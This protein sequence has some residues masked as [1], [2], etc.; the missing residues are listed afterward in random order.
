M[1][2]LEFQNYLQVLYMGNNDT[3][4]VGTDSWDY[5]SGLLRTAIN[6]WQ[7]EEGVEW[8]ELWV[9][10]SDGDGDTTTDGTSSTY[11]AA[12]DFKKPGGYL[13][14]IDSSG[15]KTWYKFIKPSDVQV[16]LIQN[17]SEKYF[18]IT[19]NERVGFTVNLSD[20]PVAGLTIEY[21]YYKE[22][23]VPISSSH[24]IEMNDAWFAVHMSL[25][26]L[27]GNAENNDKASLELSVAQQKLKAMKFRNASSPAHQ[28]QKPSDVS[29]NSGYGGFGR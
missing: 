27:Q 15:G 2:L 13:Y 22:A 24:I 11:D 8:D 23:F 6:M 29:W 28:T 10:N 25:S 9:L 12:T 4:D 26:Y 14:L 3:P 5:R 21:S 7:A 18:W 17:S 1:T 16:E 19:G 20:T